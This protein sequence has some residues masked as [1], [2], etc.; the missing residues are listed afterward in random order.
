MGKFKDILI[1]LEDGVSI[2][3][4]AK[5]YNIDSTFVQNIFDKITQEDYNDYCGD[6]VS[7]GSFLKEYDDGQIPF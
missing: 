1:E 2:D 6:G 4:V 5:H 7:S 3:K